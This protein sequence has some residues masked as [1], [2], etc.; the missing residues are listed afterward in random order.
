MQ[1]SLEKEQGVTLQGD[2]RGI[3]VRCLAGV[4]WLTQ[5]GDERDYLLRPEEEFVVRRRGK[6]IIE[7]WRDAVLTLPPEAEPT[8]WLERLACRFAALRRPVIPTTIKRTATVAEG[9]G[10]KTF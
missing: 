1:I 4:L 6:V 7:A 10:G 3:R 5:C 8:G 9:R 2:C